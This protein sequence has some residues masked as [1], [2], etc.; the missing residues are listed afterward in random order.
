MSLQPVPRRQWAVRITLTLL[1]LWVLFCATRLLRPGATFSPDEANYIA[2]AHRLIETHTYSYWGNGPDAYVPPVYPLFLALCMKLFGSDDGG[3]QRIRLLQALL[4]M[5]AVLLTFRLGRD[6]TGRNRVGITACALVAF[7]LTYAAY[8]HLFL[9][10]TLYFFLM[11][12]FFVVFLRSSRQGK[13]WLYLLS[14]FLCAATLLTR[15]LLLIA[16]PLLW[17]P[18]I[19]D[20]RG[21]ANLRS[22]LAP[23]G[24]FAAGFLI[25]ALPW[26]IRNLATLHRFIPLCTQSNPIFAGLAPD[27]TGYTDPGTLWGN[28][29]LFFTLFFQHPA[30][31]LSWMTLGKFGVIFQTPPAT[32]TLKPITTLCKDVSTYVG[33]L[34]C[35]AALTRREHIWPVTVLLV[36]LAGSFLTVPTSRYALQ[37]LPLLSIAAGY[38]IDLLFPRKSLQTQ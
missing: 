2:M 6:L 18:H 14:G 7:N 32:A 24:L 22:L 20:H 16:V 31:T 23:M 21:K 3:L 30:D 11:L 25:L 35:A 15:P 13:P 5:G 36:Y 29:K 26:W 17:I 28:L 34:G 27:M 19:L 33:L 12:L 1:C 4:A 8:S 10:E 38:A 9:T 37:Y